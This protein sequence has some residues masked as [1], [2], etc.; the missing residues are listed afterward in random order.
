MTGRGRL[1]RTWHW[2]LSR[3]FVRLADAH[4]HFGNQYGN[5]HEHG[6]AIRNY[7]RAI[8]F[9]PGY[10]QAYYSRGVL[11]WREVRDHRRAIDDLTRAIELDPSRADAYF[12]R[13]MAHQACNDAERATADL[14]QYLREGHD[15]YWIESARLQLADLCDKA[16]ADESDG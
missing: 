10:A 13:A 11:Y 12:T 8:D 9:D 5:R 2:A 4:R 1:K 16:G 3:F 15:P 14:E 6:S 7:T